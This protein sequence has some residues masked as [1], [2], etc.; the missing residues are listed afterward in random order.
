[1]PL[2]FKYDKNVKKPEFPY[3]CDVDNETFKI[4]RFLLEPITNLAEYN[5]FLEYFSEKYHLKNS[6]LL[7]ICDGINKQ[8]V[9][10]NIDTIDI[11]EDFIVNVSKVTSK[12]FKKENR[13]I[14]FRKRINL[15]FI[16]IRKKGKLY[17]KSFKNADIED[18][19]KFRDKLEKD[20]ELEKDCSEYLMGK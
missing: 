15:T 3:F 4:Y 8:L 14:H 16:Q 17:Y 6:T 9:E 12:K 5:Q 11:P 1:M 19:R 7:G 2:K 20:L 13:N 18:V 10:N